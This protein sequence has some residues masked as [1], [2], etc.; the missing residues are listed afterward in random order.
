MTGKKK[1]PKRR[2]RGKWMDLATPKS[3][4]IPQKSESGDVIEKAFETKRKKLDQ[5]I[6]VEGENTVLR[7]PISGNRRSKE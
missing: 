3:R 2:K 7:F 1:S 5:T 6:M 4:G